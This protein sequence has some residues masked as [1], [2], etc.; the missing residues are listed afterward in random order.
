[1]TVFADDPTQF[2]RWVRAGDTL[3]ADPA[4]LWWEG[5]AF[6]Q[7][8]VF[9]RYVAG[10]VDQARAARPDV[11]IAHH[12]T[13]VTGVKAHHDRYTIELASDA[14]LT[15][16]ILVLAVSHP[17]PSVPARLAAALAQGA[18]IIANPWQPGALDTIGPDAGVAIIGAGLTAADAV[19]TLE[20][21]GHR[22]TILMVSRRGLL[23]RGH[24]FGDIAKRGFFETAPRERTA[25]GLCRL[26]RDQ[27]AQAAAEGAPWQAVFDDV[28]ANARR[29]WMALPEA[30]QRR[31]VR[32][33]RPY[34]DVHRFRVAPQ[35]EAA[36]ARLRATGALT[37]LAASVQGA[38]W[39]GATLTLHLRPRGTSADGIISRTVGAVVVTTGPAHGSALIV[40]PALADLE[41]QG[42]ICADRVGLG[43]AV[44]ADSHAVSQNGVARPSLLVAG[45]LARGRFGE[46]MGLP[47]VSEHAAT[48]A[49]VV[50]AYIARP[51]GIDTAQ[52]PG[53]VAFQPG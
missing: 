27:V 3:Q 31:I 14:C 30:E 46:L 50:L 12:R 10:L 7:R 49:G 38:D 32:H 48:V 39:D 17:P 4:A 35:V 23:S 37:S 9:G 36:M 52:Q 15:A 34:W 16:D 2:D 18:P 1:M 24:A 22:G 45:P 40:N 28:R 29:L 5:S 53:A 6:P 47:Q 26:I 19:A 33:I 11:T 44:D 20:R 41:R 13:S 25:L 43:L 42:L 51:V 21:R 8:G